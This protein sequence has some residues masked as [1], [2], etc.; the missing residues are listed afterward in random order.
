MSLSEPLTQSPRRHL[1]APA[2][3]L[4]VYTIIERP[5]AEK[6]LWWRVGTPG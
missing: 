3:R 1:K 2:K 5:G 4:V 6:S